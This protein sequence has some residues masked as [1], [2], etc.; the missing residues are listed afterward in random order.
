MP[1]EFFNEKLPAEVLSKLASFREFDKF[2]DVILEADGSSKVK[3]E[4]PSPTSV[5]AHK[6]VLA[7]ASPY[8]RETLSSGSYVE[9][10]EIRVVVKDIDDKTLR[11]LVD[12]MYTGRLDIDE[13]NVQALFGAAKILRLD[14]FHGE[15]AV[16]EAVINWVKHDS[17]RRASLPN[18]LVGVRLPLISR[19]FLL[20]RVYNEPLRHHCFSLEVISAWQRSV[21]QSTLLVEKTLPILFDLQRLTTCKDSWRAGPKMQHCRQALGVTTLD[22]IIFAVGGKGGGHIFREAEMLDPR[23]GKWISLPSMRNARYGCGLTAVNGLLYAAGGDSDRQNFNSV[24]VYDPRACRWTAAQPMLKKRYFTLATV[25]RDQVV[26]VGGL[27][28]KYTV[29][30]SA[31]VRIPQDNAYFGITLMP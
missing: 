12:Y 21:I 7:A 17:S 27:D 24:E 25:F 22:G 10:K 1:P 28:E 16:F 11:L 30:S 26:V 5:R 19:E 29:L 13:K 18:V 4:P 23:Q 9:C 2:C 20:D 31:E 8:F 6:L 15:D 14:S 3:S